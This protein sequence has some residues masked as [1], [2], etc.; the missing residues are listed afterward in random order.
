MT[1]RRFLRWSI[2]AVL[3]LLART[4]D[5]EPAEAPEASV[6]KQAVEATSDAIVG[7]PTG[8]APVRLAEVRRMELPA[9]RVAKVYVLPISGEVGPT[10]EYIVRRGLREALEQK[11][12]LVVV[13]MNT[14][15]GSVAFTLEIIE[16]IDRFE[17]PTATFVN[18]EAA[19]AGAIIA[20]STR[21]I[22]MTERAVIGAAEPVTGSGQ[23]V[24]EA[25]KRKILSY[26]EAKIRS[27]EGSQATRYRAEVLAAM[28]NPDNELVVGGEV[29]KK[30]DSLL[31]LTA[32]E[33]A[34]LHGDPPEPLLASGI[35]GDLPSLLDAKFGPGRW[36]E[37]R[38]EVTWSVELAR[39][40]TQ[41][42]VV[43]LLLGAGLL[44][45]YIEFK[46]PGFGVFGILGGVFL[47]LVFFGHYVAG[48]A[49]YEPFLFFL[50]G[51]AFLFVEL[52]FFPGTVVLALTGLLLMAGSL[53]WAMAG[54]WPTLD[55]SAPEL[56]VDMFIKPTIQALVGCVIGGVGAVVAGRYLPRTSFFRSLA[57]GEAGVGPGQAAIT[58]E[59]V[60][61]AAPA[62][63]DALVGREGTVVTALTPAGRVEVGGTVY[64]ASSVGGRIEPGRPVRVVRR[65]TFTLH[66]E[67]IE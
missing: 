59:V 36:E 48:L 41:S 16:M 47:A 21:D 35:A 66:V 40:L 67:G 10:T 64:E 31:T 11:V 4:V 60:G 27:L 56:A 50:V 6:T 44:C 43:S 61:G 9:D 34:T 2:G 8:K 14:P 49:G 18:S 38:F 25:M 12:D 58:S 20:A 15:G 63:L 29:L 7:E 5:A 28:M 19:S 37:A 39:F 54:V 53:L 57:I 52:F 32:R 24:D 42:A 3:L 65:G 1:F 17:G 55:G 62:S 13:D 51:V 46:T 22:Y 26:L 30:A 23:D 33:A 45:L